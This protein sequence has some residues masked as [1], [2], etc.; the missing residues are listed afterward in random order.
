MNKRAMTKKYEKTEHKVLFI[1]VAVLY[2]AY[3]STSHGKQA[4][5]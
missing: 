2:K 3:Y 5:G 1:P 4:I